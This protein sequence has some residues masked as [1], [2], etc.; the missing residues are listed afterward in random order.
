MD[1]DPTAAAGLAFR[2]FLPLYFVTFIVV[3][4]PL[5]AYLFRRKY[6]FDPLALEE[7]DPVMQFGEAYRNALFGVVLLLTLAHAFRPA[8]VEYLGPIAHLRSPPI[9][10][11]GVAVLAASLVLVRVGQLQLKSSW[12]FGVDRAHP[13]DELITSGLFALSRNPIY[14]GML[15]SGV[16]LFLA[17]PNAVTFAIPNVAFVLL[18]T[19][20]RAEEQFMEEVYGEEYRAY[21]LRTAR[22]LIAPKG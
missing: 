7:P 11:T 16:G 6:G 9:R 14:L 20:I 5:S 12:R 15:M 8:V 22:W 13:P 19:R 1:P 21:R 3:G 10:A 2:V 4:G 17:L 18:Q